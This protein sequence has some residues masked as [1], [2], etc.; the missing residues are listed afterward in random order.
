MLKIIRKVCCKCNTDNS[1]NL[2]LLIELKH[3]FFFLE[4]G[5]YSRSKRVIVNN[6]LCSKSPLQ[7]LAVVFASVF[8]KNFT[9]LGMYTD[10]LQ[11]YAIKLAD[12]KKFYWDAKWFLGVY[13][14]YWVLNNIM[15][16]KPCLHSAPDIQDEFQRCFKRNCNFHVSFNSFCLTS[17]DWLF[18]TELIDL[19]R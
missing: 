15:L 16:Y 1:L 13:F 4:I 12:W 7:Y 14:S 19:Y 3:F 2:N 5:K 9:K 8:S 17:L 11:V 6:L 18:E 10:W